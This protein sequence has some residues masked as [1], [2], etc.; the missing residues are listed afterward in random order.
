MKE[1][2]IEA[3]KTVKHELHT[4]QSDNYAHIWGAPALGAYLIGLVMIDD[5]FAAPISAQEQPIRTCIDAMEAAHRA[6]ELESLAMLLDVQSA[7]FIKAFF[8]SDNVIAEEEENVNVGAENEVERTEA[9]IWE[10]EE[11]VGDEGMVEEVEIVTEPERFTRNMWY[12]DEATGEHFEYVIG[13]LIPDEVTNKQYKRSTKKAYK[14]YLDSLVE[15]TEDLKTPTEQLPL[16]AEPVEN[17][18][19]LEETPDPLAAWRI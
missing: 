19:V 3:I 6:R 7:T 16:P 8:Q 18:E 4:Y 9:V 11:I 13:A 1:Q 5:R 14:A 10:E 17:T 12:V 15:H 2:V